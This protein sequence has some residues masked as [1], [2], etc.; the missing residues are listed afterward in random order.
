MAKIVKVPQLPWHGPRDL[1]LLLPDSWQVEICNIAGYNRPAMDD[2]QIKASITRLIGM[3]PLREFARGKKE[4]VIIF[5]DITRV[6]RVAKIVPFVLEELAEA[7]IPDS[8]IRFIAALGN[9]GA[10]NR[11]DFAK[12]LGESTLARFPVYNHNPHGN[13]TYVGSTSY[14]TKL[15]VNAEVMH[16]DLKITIGSVVPH[17]GTV[18]SGGGKMILPGVASIESIESNHALPQGEHNTKSMRLDVEEAAKL[19]ALDVVIECIVNQWGDT[20]A[21]FAGTETLAH[22][23]AVKEARTHYI[24][25]KAEGKNIVIANAYA[26]VSESA[27]G[28]RKTVMSLHQQKGGSFVLI[29]N[30]PNG[31]VA[32]YFAP[33]WGRTKRGKGKMP[34][35]IP[36]NVNHLIVY[37]EYPDIAGL[38]FIGTPEK[39]LQMSNWDDL[40][41]TLKGFHDDNATVAVYPNSE[42]LLF[43]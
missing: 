39:I 43:G 42:I 29:T 6:T 21:I 18:F 25:P 7:N 13:C 37:N 20:V 5:D 40:I 36:L 41:W 31:Q 38:G 9:H 4:V 23:A 24:C 14:G 16:C 11:E 19:A 30:A 17:A 33:N 8:R 1:D 2:D 15:F 28:F 22:E 27:I 32:H 35:P 10:M 26:K 3:P 34:P 12:K